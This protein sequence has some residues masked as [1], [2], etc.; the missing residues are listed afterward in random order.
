MKF[1]GNISVIVI[2]ITIINSENEEREIL[3]DTL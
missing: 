1:H 2:V 3:E